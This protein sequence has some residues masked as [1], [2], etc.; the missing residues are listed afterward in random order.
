[1]TETLYPSSTVSATYSTINW[2]VAAQLHSAL[3]AD[4]ASY[5]NGSGRSSF[6][7]AMPNPTMTTAQLAA[8][9]LEFDARPQATWELNTLDPL[10]GE[11]RDRTGTVYCR[12]G[13]TRFGSRRFR[14][15]REALR[16][17]D[18]ECSVPRWPAVG[19]R[20]PV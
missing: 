11:L 6:V 12:P 5:V 9:K 19:R 3:D 18:R 14:S 17:A 2:T 10:V 16:R 1:M 8:V 7:C 15:G 13:S 4:P 20:T